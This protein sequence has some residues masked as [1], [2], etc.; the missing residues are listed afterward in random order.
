MMPRLRS[1]SKIP[2]AMYHRFFAVSFTSAPLAASMI[3]MIP[4]KMT[5]VID[6]TIVILSIHLA[7]L[8]IKGA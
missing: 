4:L 5:I 6:R 3:Y 7:M 2:P 1:A 8:T